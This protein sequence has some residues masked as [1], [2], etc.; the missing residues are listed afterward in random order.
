MTPL[1]ADA[2]RAALQL[3][4]GLS[5]VLLTLLLGAFAAHEL[6]A[7][8]LSWAALRLMLPAIF[9]GARVALDAA[10]FQR[11]AGEADLDAAMTRFDRQ[12]TRWKLRPAAGPTRSLHTRIDGALRLRRALFACVAAQAACAVSAWWFR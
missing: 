12:L 1:H 4:R 5:A 11:W 10:V 7:G 8:V 2:N 6:P 3:R 9:F